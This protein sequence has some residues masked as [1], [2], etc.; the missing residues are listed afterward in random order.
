[1]AQNIIESRLIPF[2]LQI[3]DGLPIHLSPAG[4]IFFDRTIGLSYQNLN[5]Q[6]T[7]G[8]LGG[9]G[10]GS[11]FTGGTVT[12]PTIFLNGLTSNTILTN[13]IS[14]TTYFGLP[15]DIFVTG[16]TYNPSLSALT[17]TNTTGGTFTVTGITS[18]GGSTVDTFVTG[19]T[20]NNSNILTI[21]QNQG[22]PDLN[23]LF[24]TVTGLTTDFFDFN[25]GATV[26]PAVSRLR[27]NDADGTLDI[28]LKGGNVTLQIGQE[29]VVRVV[30]KTGSNLLESNYQV[31][32]VR[33]AAEGGA[34]GQRL[35]ILLAQA[36]TEA[37]H[38]GVL[39]LVTENIDNNQE[40]FITTFGNVRRI[41]TTGSLQGETWVDGDVL[42]LSETTA[43]RLTNIKPQ[44]HPVQI[45][46]VVYAHPNQGKIFVKVDEGVDQLSELH[47][48]NVT[49][50]TDG[51]VLTYSA[52]TQTWVPITPSGFTGGTVTGSTIF[53]N[54]LSANTFSATTYLGLPIDVRVT[55]GTFNPSL[56]AITFTNNTGGTFSVTGISV[57]GGGGGP[58]IGQLTGDVTAGPATASS[59]SVVAT[60]KPNIKTGAFG[61]TIDGLGG[62]ISS[63]E[64]GY[65]YVPYD[66]I[67]TGWS[68]AGD[69][70]GSCVVDV[71]KDSYGNFPPTSGDS[72]TGTQKPRLNGQIVNRDLSLSSWT[73]TISAGDYIGFNVEASPTGVTRVNLTITV[74]KT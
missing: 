72:I 62:V 50:A 45:G 26:T 5:G 66:G 13:T 67:I 48:V 18:G 8:L 58:S 17:F 29:E 32:R 35:A 73:T 37:N 33:T 71:W 25:T 70:V 20:Y 27:W 47:D 54:G 6:N 43:G 15:P 63:G 30:N 10:G 60:V 11:T 1:M 28:G 42:W 57:S 53:T 68:I 51:Q 14:A 52:A 61:I 3:G 19:F 34:Q 24:H 12:G 9:G 39:G 49:G 44:N 46:Y 69:R 59:E 23:A 22:Q 65:V 7:W 4:T 21:K 74:N 40:G 56:S 2:N 38:S 41:N 36:N 64:K 55:G 31:V 16:G